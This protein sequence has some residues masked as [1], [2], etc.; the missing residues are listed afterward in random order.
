[1]LASSYLSVTAIADKPL[2]LG[3]VRLAVSA[4]S[5]IKEGQANDTYLCLTDPDAAYGQSYFG[6]DAR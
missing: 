4:L 1:L 5:E 6:R 3:I 2:T